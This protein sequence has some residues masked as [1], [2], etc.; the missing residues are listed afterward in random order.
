[1]VGQRKT[2]TLVNTMTL[3][4]RIQSL[5]DKESLSNRDLAKICDVQPSAVTKWA[6]N[7]G[8]SAQNIATISVHFGVTSDWLLGIDQSDQSPEKANI[9]RLKKGK[10]SKSQK[11]IAEM[12]VCLD[13]LAEA[14]ES[15]KRD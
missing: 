3:W 9:T 8:V 12:R 6:R 2:N 4:E 13:R 5:L 1:M 11:A 15:L 10:I 14:V 7:K